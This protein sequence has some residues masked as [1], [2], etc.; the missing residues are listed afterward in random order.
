[1]RIG[2]VSY[3]INCNFTNYGSALQSW[4]LSETLQKLGH[5]P[6]L[7][8]YCPDIL[9][10]KDPLNPMKNMW[11][12]D[13]EA[14]RQCELSLPAIRVNYEKFER[15]YSTRFN[16]SAKKYY[17]HNFNAVVED[18][19]IDAFVCG[20]DTIFCVDEFGIDDGYYANY[21]CMKNGHTISY[22]ASFGD[23]HFTPETYALLNERLQ[24]FKAIGIRESSMLPYVR[25]QVSVR[26]EKVLD[27]TL[28]LKVED[29]RRIEAPRLE[30]ER[31]ILLYARRY[32]KKMFEYADKKAKELGC[33]VIDISLRATNA[34]KHRMFYEAGV[35]EFL[36]L[37]HHA[38]LVVTNSFHGM[39]VAV[40]YQ[41]P[42]VIFSREQCDTKIDEVLSLLG[43]T[44]RKLVSGEETLAAD[45]DY[46]LVHNR[47]SAARPHSLQFLAQE[48]TFTSK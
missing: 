19:G 18:E 8:D 9:R 45:I 29:F 43:L 27:P 35:E 30:N 25:Q 6:V 7:I 31:Y 10:D 48:L 21:A 4:A 14:R 11:D 40:H 32:N 22:A 41:R 28:L 1:M 37:V 44:D 2:I 33:K 24:N 46:K 17:S 47:T 13:A 15:F 39:I 5:T 34:D 38:E 42:F 12:T 36:S 16:R 23:S 3:N 20:S 26:V